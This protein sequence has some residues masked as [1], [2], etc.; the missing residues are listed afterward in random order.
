MKIKITFNIDESGLF[1]KVLPNE[2]LAFKNKKSEGGKT[3]KKLSDTINVLHFYID[4][5]FNRKEHF[6]DWV[7]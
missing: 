2:T 4:V 6:L 3:P 5:T 1:H 7:F